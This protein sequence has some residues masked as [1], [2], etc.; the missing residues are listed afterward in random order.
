MAE[1]QNPWDRE[2][3]CPIWKTDAHIVNQNANSI[4]VDSKR[5][6]GLYWLLGRAG[7]SVGEEDEQ[8]KALLTSLLIEKRQAGEKHPEINECTIEE[9]R[10]KRPLSVPERADRVLEYIA[11]QNQYVGYRFVLDRFTTVYRDFL[12]A[13]SE[14]MR[15]TSNEHEQEQE[16][17]I[18]FFLNY[19]LDKQWVSE[20]DSGFHITVNG[21]S[22][23]AE[24]KHKIVPSTRAF[25]AMWFD[26]KMGD[27]YLKGIKPAIESCGYDPIR[28]DQIEHTGKIDDRIIAELRKSRFVVADFTQG[29]DGARGGVYYEAG[30]AHALDIPVIFACRKD[31]MKHLHFDTRQ[32]VHIDW[33]DP[34]DLRGRLSQRINAVVI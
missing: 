20:I 18:L 12:L 28:V 13:W 2:V 23:L 5:A 7:E 4:L 32:F 27:A 10:I 9:A 6:G 25:V 8:V 21:F 34:E 24:L 11:Q 33:K 1:Y 26:E 14:S 19:L 29:E 22:H 15:P 30:F 17:E 16:E 3:E 31:C